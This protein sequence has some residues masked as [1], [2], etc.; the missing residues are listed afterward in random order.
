[1][2]VCPE[3]IE[4]IATFNFGQLRRTG[5]SNINLCAVYKLQS[6]YVPIIIFK[7]KNESRHYFGRIFNAD[8]HTVAGSHSRRHFEKDFS[9]MAS[10]SG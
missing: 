9:K 4:L 7:L 1:M 8:H 5:M 2:P 6:I 10:D 3:T